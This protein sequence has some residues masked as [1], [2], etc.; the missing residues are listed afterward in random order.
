MYT[1]PFKWPKEASIIEIPAMPTPT[2]FRQWRTG[3]REAV[4]AAAMDPQQA[5][6]WIKE[7][8]DRQV[9]FDM[10]ADS[11]IFVALDTKLD[12]GPTKMK[13]KNNQVKLRDHSVKM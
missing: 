6:T 4:A 5:F 13:E 1:S 2:G 7:V 12:A 9:T 10:L 3:V 8:E 11:K